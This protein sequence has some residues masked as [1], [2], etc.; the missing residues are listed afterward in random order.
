MAAIGDAWTERRTNTGLLQK[1]VE[2]F[3]MFIG[4]KTRRRERQLFEELKL[5]G[6]LKIYSSI[7]GETLRQ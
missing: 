7:F 4:K 3:V 2:R 5:L 6:P 1:K